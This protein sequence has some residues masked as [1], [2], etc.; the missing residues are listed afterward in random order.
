M[1]LHGLGFYDPCNGDK[2]KATFQ[3]NTMQM[4]K[5]CYKLFISYLHSK[6]IAFF[7]GFLLHRAECPVNTAKF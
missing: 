4:G 2:I 1:A 6:R 5:R 3:V 7:T